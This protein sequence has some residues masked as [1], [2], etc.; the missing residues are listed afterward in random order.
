MA[1]A[2]TVLGTNKKNHRGP[3]RPPPPPVIGLS[4]AIMLHVDKAGQLPRWEEAE[5]SEKGM[6]KNIRRAIEAAH[7]KIKNTFNRRGLFDGTGDSQII[8]AETKHDY[9]DQ[10]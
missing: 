7:I 9:L 8:L 10:A 5:N 6:C 2:Q 4:N 1:V 3:I